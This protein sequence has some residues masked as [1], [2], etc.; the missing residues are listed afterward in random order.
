[1]SNYNFVKLEKKNNI[2]YVIINRPEALNALN[3]KVLSDIMGAFNEIR[4]DDDIKVVILTGEGRSFVAGADIAQM[5]EQDMLDG[6][7]FIVYGQSVMNVLENFDKPIIAAVNGFALG[8]GCELAMSADIRIASVKAKFGQPEVGLGII[9]GFGGTQRLSRLIGKGNA[10]YLIYT[11]DIINA[12]EAYRMGLVQKIVEPEKLIE[13][14]ENIA[15]K[16]IGKAPVAIK[17]AKKSIDNGSNVDINTGVNYEAEAFATCF[18]TDDR[19]EGMT[20]FL[21]KRQANFKNI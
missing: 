9:P 17:M 2:G 1:M 3:Q 18:A 13:E 20:A 10:K 5:K 7:E 12:E 19:I 8:G 15:N 11:A 21:E 16:I 4:K 14:C 6:R